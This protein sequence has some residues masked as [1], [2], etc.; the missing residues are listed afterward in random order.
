MADCS[1]SV[2][3]ILSERYKAV[4]PTACFYKRGDIFPEIVSGP[5]KLSFLKDFKQS[6]I[7]INT[8]AK[9]TS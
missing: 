6:N 4:S 1:N 5:I 2:S 7:Y 8:Q 3:F 9:T